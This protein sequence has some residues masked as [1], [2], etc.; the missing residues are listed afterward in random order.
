MGAAGGF[1]GGALVMV[2]FSLIHGALI[3]TSLAAVLG[4]VVMILVSRYVGTNRESGSTLPRTIRLHR[5][6]LVR[7]I[8]LTPAPVVAYVPGTKRSL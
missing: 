2:S 8:G 4:A 5:S 6:K 3:Y 7:V 1:A